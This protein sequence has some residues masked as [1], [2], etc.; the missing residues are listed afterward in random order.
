LSAGFFS[1]AGFMV[2]FV[3]ERSRH[4][5]CFSITILIIA[6]MTT[7]LF[8]DDI[9]TLQS[10]LTE[11]TSRT[12]LARIPAPAYRCLED[13]SHDRR[14]V[15]P[16]EPNGWHTNQDHEQFIR[17][18]E[19]EGRHE[20][21]IMEHEGPGAIVRIWLPL[22]PEMD[23]QIIRFYFDGSAK[24]EIAAKFN[25][26]IS[27]HGF[28]KPPFA[29]VSWDEIDLRNQLG[30]PDTRR[31]VG[32]DLYLPIPYAKSCKITLDQIPFYYIVNYRAYAPGTAVRTFTMNECAADQPYID[33]AAQE[34][35]ESLRRK[36]PDDSDSHEDPVASDKSVPGTA[37]GIATPKAAVD[38]TVSAHAL[39]PGE[40][41]S[42]ELR[43][44]P[45]AV[46]SLRVSLGD[47]DDENSLRSTV[48]IATFDDEPTIWCP[49]S[50]FFGAGVR[51]HPVS[52]RFRTVTKDGDLSARWI[53]PYARSG[54]V[55][56]S[57]LG[58]KPLT[59]SLAART[60][61]WNWDDR[62]MHFHANWRCQFEI[63]TRPMSDWNYLEVKGAGVY[64]GDTLTVY[65]PHPYWYGEGDERIYVDGER[66]PSHLGT[67][68]ED[69]YGYAWGMADYFSSPFISMPQRDS[70]GDDW[71]GYT[72]TSRVRVLDA[73]PFESSLQHDMEIWNW[74]D[75]KV[76]YA[77][78]T[79]WYARPGSSN[80]RDAQPMEAATPV[81]ARPV[82][83]RQL[84][85]GAIECESLSVCATSPGL[86][87][88]KQDV[89]GFASGRWSGGKHLWVKANKVGDFM[90]LQIPVADDL[91]R[92]VTLFGTKSADYGTL[93]FTVNGQAAGN[94]FDGYN[95]FPTDS[96][97]IELGTFRPAKG[98][99]TLRVEVV[100]SNPAAVNPATYFG[101]DCITLTKTP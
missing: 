77:V 80:N 39:E 23:N 92:K 22:K 87:W 53:M 57:N 3:S 91:P 38:S 99:L 33:R 46:E 85:A 90:E 51:R 68:T 96:G 30:T 42:L 31:G 37:K 41:V 63:P 24:P 60:A 14:K 36:D 29:F 21:V 11:M 94:N 15:D 64:V 2:E 55:T 74:A 93:R 81:H 58:S 86:Q 72:T 4:R 13:S 10:L 18:E 62:S 65:S 50:E 82:D 35:M 44:G 49:L 5:V 47:V 32:S 59:V 17:E 75:T 76:D 97:P 83:P 45:A 8:G 95:A 101:L 56:L 25:A 28:V 67:G 12:A 34:L 88:E 52:D 48:L 71:R 43:S 9:V 6:L 78:G 70:K 40:S 19:N 98:I 66:F 61:A 26:L 73:I 69:Y 84:R 20:W 16:N 100:G 7:H 54:R 89:A 79:F 27:G 1:E